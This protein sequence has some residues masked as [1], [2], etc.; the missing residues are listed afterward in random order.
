MTLRSSGLQS[1]SDLDSIRNSC[2]VFSK[3]ICIQSCFSWMMIPKGDVTKSLK[4]ASSATLLF[5]NDTVTPKKGLLHSSSCWKLYASPRRPFLWAWKLNLLRFPCHV[6]V[7]V[8]VLF[9]L[10]TLQD[11]RDLYQRLMWVASIND[12]TTSNADNN[13]WRVLASAAALFLFGTDSLAIHGPFGSRK[14][15]E[16]ILNTECLTIFFSR[17]HTD[18]DTYLGR[19]L[20]QY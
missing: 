18:N 2:D 8:W 10:N 15:S 6:K 14:V 20:H 17:Y 4:L 1:D 7:F 16:K 11:E 13:M 19:Y 3:N 9:F 12:R 5:F